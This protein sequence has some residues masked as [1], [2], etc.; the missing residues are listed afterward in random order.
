MLVAAIAD[1]IRSQ[2]ASYRIR[3][4]SF[5]DPA[6]SPQRSQRW[7]FPNV[8]FVKKTMD[9]AVQCAVARELESSWNQDVHRPLLDYVF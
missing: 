7:Q 3:D 2:L 1:E 9:R 5:Y 6:T 8:A 4:F